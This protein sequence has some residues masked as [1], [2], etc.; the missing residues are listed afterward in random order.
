[1]GNIQI[2]SNK[3]TL[4]LGG[5]YTIYLGVSDYFLK[6]N[7]SQLIIDRTNVEEGD[8]IL[9]YQKSNGYSLSRTGGDAEKLEGRGIRNMTKQKGQVL[10]Y[11]ESWFNHRFHYKADPRE[12]KY[13]S[14]AHKNITT[15]AI[16]FGTASFSFSDSKKH[17]G[18]EIIDKSNDIVFAD[19]FG[20]YSVGTKEPSERVV[21][22]TGLPKRTIRYIFQ[23]YSS[24]GVLKSSLRVHLITDPENNRKFFGWK[25]RDEYSNGSDNRNWRM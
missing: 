13:L 23:L 12:W 19:G 25:I 6:I 1:M 15:K 21:A 8:W 7:G 22:E 20:E 17:K 3:P 10:S 5:T 2:V 11:E 16:K 4:N 24:T 9:V 18:F 14:A